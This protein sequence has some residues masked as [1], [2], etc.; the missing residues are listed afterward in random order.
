MVIQTISRLSGN[1]GRSSRAMFMKYANGH[2]DAASSATLSVTIG[3]FGTRKP[4]MMIQTE[5][6][7]PPRTKAP[8]SNGRLVSSVAIEN[9]TTTSNTMPSCRMVA[10]GT[11]RYC[12][13]AIKPGGKQ[14][15]G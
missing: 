5:R 2:I 8:G 3:R 9:A 7:E 4:T 14:H 13:A 12:C 11:T 10:G 1:G 15:V 6:F